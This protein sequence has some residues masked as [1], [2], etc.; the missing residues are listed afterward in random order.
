[1][2]TSLE[3]IYGKEDT[4]MKRTANTKHERPTPTRLWLEIQATPWSVIEAMRVK[5]NAA[6]TTNATAK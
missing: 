3:I 2:G 1:V 4:D 6:P 5:G